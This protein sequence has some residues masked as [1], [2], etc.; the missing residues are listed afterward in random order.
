MKLNEQQKK[1]FAASAAYITGKQTLTKVTG[2]PE[3]LE[4]T[5]DALESSKA[6]YEGLKAP[7]ASLSDIMRLVEEKNRAAKQ[8]YRCA[9]FDWIL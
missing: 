9:G 5:R 6:L 2:D 1:F 4:A 7:G 3:K 8:F